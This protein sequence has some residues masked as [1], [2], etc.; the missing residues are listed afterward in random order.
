MRL[1]F[2]TRITNSF[3]TTLTNTWEPVISKHL[4]NNRKKTDVLNADATGPERV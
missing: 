4:F 3:R 2:L 1:C